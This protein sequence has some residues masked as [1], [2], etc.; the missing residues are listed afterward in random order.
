MRPERPR[1]TQLNSQAQS[2]VV[3]QHARHFPGRTRYE[4]R[5]A[6]ATSPNLTLYVS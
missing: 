6:A 2:R 4:D 5:E 3:Q 1:T